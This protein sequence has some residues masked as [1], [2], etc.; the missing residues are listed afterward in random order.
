VTAE[1][2]LDARLADAPAPLATR[3]RALLGPALRRDAHDL[4]E[5]AVAA[6]AELVTTLVRDDCTGRDSALDLLAADALVTYAFESAAER[7]DRL[8]ERARAALARLAQVA[9]AAPA[10]ARS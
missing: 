5:L 10:E 1:A 4:P 3:V 9:D 8:A 7:P 6:A 2:W